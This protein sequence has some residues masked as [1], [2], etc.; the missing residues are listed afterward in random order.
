MN[1]CNY[2]EDSKY[3]QIVITSRTN[4]NDKDEIGINLYV[5]DIQFIPNELAGDYVPNQETFDSESYLSRVYQNEYLDN[6][7]R[8][9]PNREYQASSSEF[10]IEEKYFEGESK[11]RK[12][13]KVT[14]TAQYGGMVYMLPERVHE[15]Q[16]DQIVI[17]M[18]HEYE[19]QRMY[20]GVL[21]ADYTSGNYREILEMG[22]IKTLNK[23]SLN[24][25]RIANGYNST[26][27]GIDSHVTGIWF[28]CKDDTRTGNVFYIDSIEIIL[29]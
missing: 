22:S 10:S 13:L 29:K 2:D 21:Q 17:T 15:D 20:V 9:N 4:Y 14:T 25:D 27:T 26:F 6:E 28:A 24:G 5:D 16:I 3:N 23:Y 1:H 11:P 18:S 8:T 19:M 7:T 12:V